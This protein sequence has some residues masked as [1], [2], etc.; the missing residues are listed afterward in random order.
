VIS[1]QFGSFSGLLA[2]LGVTLALIRFL[3]GGFSSL[4]PRARSAAAL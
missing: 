1:Y 2:L 4:L 3:P